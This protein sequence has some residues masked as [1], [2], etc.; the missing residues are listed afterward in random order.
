MNPLLNV[1]IPISDAHFSAVETE[2]DFFNTISQKRPLLT[3]HRLGV[4]KML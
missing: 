3:V 1:K 4:L 2:A